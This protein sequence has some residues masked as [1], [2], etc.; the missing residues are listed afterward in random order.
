MNMGFTEILLLT[1]GL[2]VILIFILKPRQGLLLF[3]STKFTVDIFWDQPIV[4]G[5]NI[6]KI[7]GVV[8]P[9]LCIVYFFIHSPPNISQRFSKLLAGI[10]MVNIMAACW[11]YLNSTFIFFPLPHNP[12]TIQKIIDWNFRFFNMASAFLIIPLIFK[13]RYDRIVF[14]RSFLISTI[15]PALISCYQISQVSIDRM[16]SGLTE[17]YSVSLFDRINAAYHD[18]GT[19]STVIFTAL[20][21]SVALFF[22]EK[23]KSIKVWMAVYSILCSMILYFTFSRTFWISITLFLLIFFW[24]LKRYR[25]MSLVAITAVII[26]AAVPLTLKRFEREIFMLNNPEQVTRQNE[27]QKIGSGRI[28]LWNDA[29]KHYLDLDL[30]SKLIGSGGAFGSHNQYIAWLLRTGL[31]GLVMWSLFLYYVGIFLWRGYKNQI[32]ENRILAVFSFVLFCTITG[33]TNMATQPW[34]NVTF[35]YFFWGLMALQIQ[36]GTLN[37]NQ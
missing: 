25:S 20:I 2:T 5:F 27:L 9:L 26:I 16:L 3:F 10:F 7:M 32:P 36:A 35:T 33:L 21:L 22:L 28:W 17:P 4:A 1:Y 37:E 12:I 34:D 24:M 13:D 30:I 14:L 8:F 15:V 18:A 6:L 19:L 11:G 23:S 31:L 29:R